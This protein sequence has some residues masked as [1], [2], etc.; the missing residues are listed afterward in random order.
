MNDR[1]IPKKFRFLKKYNEND[2]ELFYNQ[3]YFSYK[4]SAF[5]VIFSIYILLSFLYILYIKYTSIYPSWLIDWPNVYRLIFVFLCP[6]LFLTIGTKFHKVI[7]F[8]NNC[9][10]KELLIWR[11]IPIP[12]KTYPMENIIAVGNNIKATVLVPFEANYVRTGKVVF[13]RHPKTKFF[14]SHK[15]VLLTQNGVLFDLPILGG[16]FEYYQDSLR[17]ARAISTY[18]NI[19]LTICEDDHRLKV[20]K[21]NEGYKFKKELIEK[22]DWNI[23]PSFS[24]FLYIILVILFIIL[25]VWAELGNK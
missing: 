11:M 4:S 19:P 20:E 23:I 13:I 22:S 16:S 2:I 7:D 12:I 25:I 15:V 18:F 24:Y 21:T 8:S 5:A 1:Q 10:K 17:L 3:I 9:V 6:T 14:H